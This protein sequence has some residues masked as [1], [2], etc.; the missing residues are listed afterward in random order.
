MF[1]RKLLFFLFLAIFLAYQF[2]KQLRPYWQYFFHI[3]SIALILYWILGIL[4]P[5]LLT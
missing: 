4:F 2:R 3:V 5:L 1:N